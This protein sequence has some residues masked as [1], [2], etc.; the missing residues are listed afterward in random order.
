MIKC[1]GDHVLGNYFVPSSP[2]FQGMLRSYV[3]MLQSICE[4]SHYE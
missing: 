3:H 2:V 4:I 1:F